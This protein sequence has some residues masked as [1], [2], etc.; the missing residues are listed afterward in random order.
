MDEAGTGE[1]DGSRGVGGP[2][3]AS[4]EAT[5]SE[6]LDWHNSESVATVTRSV[7]SS[8]VQSSTASV[9][10]QQSTIVTTES[11]WGVMSPSRLARNRNFSLDSPTSRKATMSPR[12]RG[13]YAEIQVKEFEQQLTEAKQRVIEVTEQLHG[14]RDEKRALAERIAT[15]EQQLEEARELR[16]S[17]TTTVKTVVDKLMLARDESRDLASQVAQLDKQVDLLRREAGKQQRAMDEREE[18]YQQEQARLQAQLEEAKSD[19]QAKL[20]A[21]KLELQTAKDQN[22]RFEEA[23][24]SESQSEQ[25]ASLNHALQIEISSRLSALAAV[26]VT[27]TEAANL[28]EISRQLQAQLAAEAQARQEAEGGLAEAYKHC[29]ELEERLTQAERNLDNAEVQE[30][31]GLLRQVKEANDQSASVQ[32]QVDAMTAQLEAGRQETSKLKAELAQVNDQMT[33]LDEAAEKSAESLQPHITHTQ[34]KERSMHK[35]AISITDDRVDSVI[36]QLESMNS[37]LKQ[38]RTDPSDPSAPIMGSIEQLASELETERQQRVDAEAALHAALRQAED[39]SLELRLMREQQQAMLQMQSDAAQDNA[40]LEREL[41]DAEAQLEGIHR[42]KAKLASDLRDAA[43][44]LE[45]MRRSAVGQ[46]DSLAMQEQLQHLEHAHSE[47]VR[48]LE[49]VRY[50]ESQMAGLQFELEQAL[51]QARDAEAQLIKERELRSK[52]EASSLLPAS[53]LLRAV[54]GIPQTSLELGQGQGATPCMQKFSAAFAAG[55]S[56]PAELAASNSNKPAGAGSLGA[57]NASVGST[58]LATGMGPTATRAAEVM[59]DAGSGRVGSGIW[60]AS[61][62]HDLVNVASLDFQAMADNEHELLSASIRR[63]MSLNSDASSPSYAGALATDRSSDNGAAT[64]R[65]D[66]ALASLPKNTGIILSADAS[67]AETVEK[68]LSEL[69]KERLARQRAEIAASDNAEKLT[70]L[71]WA[72]AGEKSGFA[73]APGMDEALML[74]LEEE[75]NRNSSLIDVLQT[76][77][78]H[79]ESLQ[80]RVRCLEAETQAQ[81]MQLGQLHKLAKRHI[82]GSMKHVDMRRTLQRA[83]AGEEQMRQKVQALENELAAARR[84]QRD[85]AS[86]FKSTNAKLT[87]DIEAARKQAVEAAAALKKEAEHRRRL[88]GVLEEGSHLQKEIFSSLQEL[89]KYLHEEGHLN[90]G[91]ADG[92]TAGATHQLGGRQNRG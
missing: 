87:T 78:V 64:D 81:E 39:V 85:S 74:R 5:K 35:R 82:E 31:L 58:T 22:A 15:L 67:Y 19:M 84:V 36:S 49:E 48:N 38:L 70:A 73:L 41:R 68:L 11:P 16:N 65:T 2:T 91:Q 40:R 13:V 12:L 23:L 26:E 79:Q 56:P 69:W 61:T 24:S 3:T 25:M 66:R 17:P 44:Q 46:K 47:A 54:S 80:S 92:G 37:T 7:P 60:P 83:T 32:Q 76:A 14:E 55:Q 52:L 8:V 57:H 9:V 4:K 42:E 33:R 75:R 71:A 62:H 72:A 10:E 63:D 59:A 28:Q 77:Q 45:M 89:L 21:I 88:E 50:V 18:Q 34:P 51:Q 43:S 20:Q 6:L 90:P 29:Q 1:L 86:H 27:R 30:K 53:A